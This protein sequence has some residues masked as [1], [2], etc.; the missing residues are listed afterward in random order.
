MY[1]RAPSPPDNTHALAKNY[2][3]A[4]CIIHHD[5]QILL[6]DHNSTVQP[7][8]W[9]LPGG[10]VEWREHPQETA[11]REVH[12][13]LNI[14][15]ADLTHVGDFVYKK[16]LHAVYAGQA[17]SR[18]FE[19]DT[20]ELASARW[21]SLEQIGDLAARAR[22]HAGYEYDAIREFFSDV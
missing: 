21:F 11:R 2:R 8:R 9:G 5:Q 22:L 16:R 10:H 7:T 18:A 12:E 13:E 19:L 3:T 14:T 17:S 6:A 15:L 1:H 4:R 20:S